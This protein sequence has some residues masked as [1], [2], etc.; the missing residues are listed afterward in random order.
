MWLSNLFFKTKNN[1]SEDTTQGSTGQNI[2]ENMINEETV[3][4]VL[5][6]DDEPIII[7]DLEKRV[8]DVKKIH[9]NKQDL[10]FNCITDI[11]THEEINNCKIAEVLRIVPIIEKNLQ[12]LTDK[13]SCL[14]GL[15]DTKQLNTKIVTDQNTIP[16]NTNINITSKS[17][18]EMENTT[19]KKEK[20][21]LGKISKK[22]KKLPNNKEKVS[23]KKNKTNKK[24]KP[25]T[26]N[27]T[28]KDQNDQVTNSQNLPERVKSDNQL[29]SLDGRLECFFT[30]MQSALAQFKIDQVNEK[31]EIMVHL[32]GLENKMNR[33]ETNIDKLMCKVEQLSKKNE[34]VIM[35]SKS[36]N[37]E[38]ENKQELQKSIDDI[39]LCI[40]YLIQPDTPRTQQCI[41]TDTPNINTNTNSSCNSNRC[42]CK[43]IHNTNDDNLQVINS[44][45]NNNQVK[46][47]DIILCEF[48]RAKLTFEMIKRSEHQQIVQM[49]QFSI[50]IDGKKNSNLSI[51]FEKTN[52]LKNDCV[53]E[54]NVEQKISQLTNL[55]PKPSVHH[56][57]KN[58]FLNDTNLNQP[59]SKI[60]P[61]EK[62]KICDFLSSQPTPEWIKRSQNLVV[63]DNPCGKCAK[64]PQTNCNS[65]K[66][67]NIERIEKENCDNNNTNGRV[68]EIT[69]K[70]VDP[71]ENNNDHTINEHHVVP[72]G[73]SFEKNPWT[74]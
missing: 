70:Q 19:P 21:T 2:N 66:L 42:V 16:N 20:T 25:E 24:D 23:S 39:K 56:F 67:Y 31:S 36:N 69:Q 35:E 11:K 41:T 12:T 74:V 37:L 52:H 62:N 33:N 7:N 47:G 53:Q 28:I 44:H 30:K 34:H 4:I 6:N 27:S 22:S 10:N 13:V 61:C 65:N 54:Q 59:I 68:Y 50:P 38:K 63:S 71:E 9:E 29:T 40:D 17:V 45:H 64:F 15:L 26:N 49:N 51:C 72:C 14:S 48:L 8:E 55:C 43:L 58:E 73:N 5:N 1:D 46:Y 32:S 18:N 60:S 3:E 57:F